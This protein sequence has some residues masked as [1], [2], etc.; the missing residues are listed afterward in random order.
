M[1]Y[2]GIYKVKNPKKYRGDFTNVVFRSG[3]ELKVF[4]WCDNNPDIREWSSEEVVIPYFYAVD[5]KY[6]RYFL[7]TA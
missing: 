1:A 3:W 6:H 2:S 7:S 5:K 4:I